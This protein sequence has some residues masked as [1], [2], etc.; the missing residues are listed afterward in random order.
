VIILAEYIDIKNEP[1]VTGVMIQYYYVSKKELWYF[2]N[3]VNMNYD[4]DNINIGRQ[5]QDSSFSRKSTRN[6]LIDGT[7]S[8]DIIVGKNKIYEV[9]KSSALKKPAIMQ[10]KYYLWYLKNKKGVVMKGEL[11]IPE[12]NKTEAVE[13]TE[14]D[15]KEI[16]EVV[17]E[18]RDIITRKN[19]PDDDL[20]S[21]PEKATYSDFF[22]V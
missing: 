20:K 13:L 15:E 4:D 5:I 16:Q 18:I 1:K 9:K 8:I 11:K 22:R 21:L 10:L 2:A 19:P 12:E 14:S 3:N 6:V 7:I 17:N